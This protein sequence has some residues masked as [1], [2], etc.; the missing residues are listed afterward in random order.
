MAKT[1]CISSSYLFKTTLGSVNGSFTEGNVSTV[2]KITTP[3]GRTRPYISGQS[4]RHAI[5]Q[6]IGESGYEL[7]PLF[8]TENKKGV[9]VSA[10]LPEKYIDDDLF[11]YMIASKSENRR[12]TAPVRV[13]A[14]VGLFPFRGDRDLGT[15]SKEQTGEAGMEAGGN[16]FET[17]VYYNYFR[18]TILL[19]VDRI[20]VY[21]AFELSKDE[22]EAVVKNGGIKSLRNET[23]QDRLRA[24]FSALTTLWG[25]GKQSRVLTDL[26]PKFIV[27]T[28][29]SAKTPVLLENLVVNDKEELVVEPILETLRDYSAII[30]KTFIGLRSGIFRNENEV[31]TTLSEAGYTVRAIN[32]SLAEALNAIKDLE[33]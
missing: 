20:G 11:G 30:Q 7:S 29:Q 6:I 16:M 25:G 10:G 1:T 28:I 31:R 32:E 3:D 22:R 4:Q 33:I 8:T 9:D 5:R 27:T 24:F 2:K 19:E 14:A 18:T 21:R 13:A 26:A 23:R 12:R 17:E 15:K